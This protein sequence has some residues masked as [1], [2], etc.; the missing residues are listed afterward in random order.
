[1]QKLILQKSLTKTVKNVINSDLYS[2]KQFENLQIHKLLG[3][4]SISRQLEK[5]FWK[6]VCHSC[7][8]FGKP[9]DGN[10]DHMLLPDQ[11]I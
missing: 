5:S 3:G 4:K 8:R 9:W 11:L 6:K 7:T 1:M 10:F 2:E